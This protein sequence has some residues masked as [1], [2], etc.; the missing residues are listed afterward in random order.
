MGLMLVLAAA[1]AAC[2]DP[3]GTGGGCTPTATRVCLTSSTFNPVTLTVTAGTTVTW[4][5]TGGSHSVTSD[6]GS[7][8]TY[9]LSVGGTT[10]ITRQF[11]TAGTFTYH[12]KFHGSPGT[13]MHGTITVNP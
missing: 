7:A 6:P 10:A 3:Y 13:N 1:L 8:E 2:G 12:C 5:P 11:N 4:Q 9:D